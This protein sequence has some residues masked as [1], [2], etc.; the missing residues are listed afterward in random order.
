MI[1]LFKDNRVGDVW[2]TR[3]MNK[4][5]LLAKDR[6]VVIRCEKQG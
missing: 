2:K 6:I 4:L 3:M 5:E 1:F